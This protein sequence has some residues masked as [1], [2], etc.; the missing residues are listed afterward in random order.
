MAEVSR[1]QFV[2]RAHSWE[3]NF[4]RRKFFKDMTLWNDRLRTPTHTAPGTRLNLHRFFAEPDATTADI[5]RR[6]C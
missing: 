3:T 1:F 5:A 2:S 4:F 6:N